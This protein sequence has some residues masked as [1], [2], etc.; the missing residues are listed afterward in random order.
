MKPITHEWVEKAE[1]DL[2][3]GTRELRARLR[4]AQQCA[5]KYLKACLQ[6]HEIHFEASAFSL[7]KRQDSGPEPRDF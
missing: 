4:P 7:H 2:V 1:G 6:E 3:T 5:E